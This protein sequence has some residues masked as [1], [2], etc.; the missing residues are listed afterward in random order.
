VEFVVVHSYE[1]VAKFPKDIKDAIGRDQFLIM[2]VYK[3]IHS[4]WPLT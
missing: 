4:R 2:D 3:Q 1:D